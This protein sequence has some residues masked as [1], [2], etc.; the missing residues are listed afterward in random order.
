MGS[1]RE[2]LELRQQELLLL[3]KKLKLKEELPHLHGFPWYPWAWDF[4]TSTNRECFL[5]AGNQL[6]KSSTQ[7]RKAIH[8]ATEPSL[9]P[10]LWPNSLSVPNCIWYLYPTRDVA[11]EEYDLKWSQFLPKG[12][13]KDSK[14]YGWVPE[15]QNR[16]IYAIHFNSGMSIYF[17]A[18]SQDVSD[19]QTGSVYAVFCDEELPTSHL[20]ELQARLNA[21]DGY[22]SMVFTATLGQEYWRKVIEGK[23][24]DEL[25]PEAWKRQVSLWDCLE[26][27]DKTPSPWTP[28]KVKRAIARCSTQA[29]IDRRIYGKF[30]VAGGLK[31]E[32]FSSE[33]NLCKPHA[34]PSNWLIYA[35]VDYGSGG[36]TNHPAAMCF[37]AVSPDFK[38]GRVFRGRRMDKIQTTAQDV[39]EEYIKQRGRLTPIVQTYD[40]SSKDF[41]TFATRRGEAF[42][43][44]NK[45]QEDG[46]QTLNTLFKAEMLKIFSP[47]PELSKLVAELSSV[48]AATLKRDAK[49]DFLD[50][51]RYAVMSV[52]WDWSVLDELSFDEDGRIKEPEVKPPKTEVQKR[53]A[54]FL[55]EDTQAEPYGEEL[56]EW[57]EMMN[58]F[59]S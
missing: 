56:D 14:Q 21:T 17:K 12:A 25:K 5:C 23:G 51:L 31:I 36:E 53:R 50:A 47:D 6:S 54:Y 35:G 59:D 39:L 11:T 34:I 30:V 32:T 58:E 29:E 13:M 15:M 33:K 45:D 57:N 1:S 40:W 3:K 10:K 20:P 4:F 9:W 18:Y 48:K 49:D 27:V 41:H 16:K 38:M 26:Y 22:F 43:K 46:V 44:A 42:V 52:P 8:W 19:L 7:I 55:G 2:V 28:D 37:V 24:D